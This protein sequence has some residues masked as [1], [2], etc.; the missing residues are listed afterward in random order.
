MHVEF[1]PSLDDQDAT[2]RICCVI[3]KVLKKPYI[4]SVCATTVLN[5][6][7]YEQG[8]SKKIKKVFQIELF[9]QQGPTLFCRQY[10]SKAI[11]DSNWTLL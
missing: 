5:V 8:F 11:L 4:I 9:A 2:K 10:A 3:I 7:S 6:D 1:L